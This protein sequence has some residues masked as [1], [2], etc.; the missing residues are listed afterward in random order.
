[1]TTVIGTDP[2]G[3]RPVVPSRGDRRPLGLNEVT[4]TGGLW[5]RLQE[6]NASATLAHCER[7][8]ERLGWL[9]NFD[10]VADGTTGPERP[11]WSFS[12]SEVYK[13]IE[14]MC[15]EH[16]R[17]GAPGLDESIRRLTARVGRAQDAD[18]YLNTC[19]GHAGRPPRYS[20]LEEGHELYN[21]GHLLQAAVARLRTS[22]AD[23]LVDLARR[24]ADHVCEVF[25][26]DGI[27]GHPE[28]EVGLAELGRAMGESR[29]VE[30]ARRFLDRRGHGTL[31]DIP[32]GRAYFQDDVPIREAATF[33]G[34]AVR[35]LYLSAA[36]VD[37]AVELADDPL[38]HAIERQ[39]EHAVARRTYLTGGMGS[40][41]QDEGF[42]EDWELPPD[43]AYCE[44]CAGVASIMVSWRL[45]LATGDVRYADL[46]ERTFYNII[47]TSPRS[48][49]RAF[50]YANPL[51]QRTP[52]TPGDDSAV[53]PRAEGGSRAAWFDVSCCP[54]NV[55]RTLA[56]W[57]TYLASAGE[58]DLTLLQY[59]PSRITTDL[60]GG[61]FAIEVDTAYPDDG[62]VTIHVLSAPRDPVALR[63]RVPP[64][65]SGA[66]LDDGGG[67][68]EV[69]PGLVAVGR[70][71]TAGETLRLRLPLAPRFTW[72]DRRVDAVRGCV[73][74][75]R[76]PLVL[77]AES[78]D[79]PGIRL[80]DVAV[81]PAGLIER[82]GQVLA[83]ARA[84][85]G[86]GSA[87]PYG[88]ASASGSG[89]AFELPLVP[90]HRWAE[91]GPTAM[92]VWLPVSGGGP[93]RA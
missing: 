31:R 52:G 27:C 21:T 87:W 66:V 54:T 14:A 88:P 10:R 16:G 92:R 5:A 73:A 46:M 83:Q 24:A 30:Q 75:E 9:A 80:D 42:G 60:T 18:G 15:W 23:E 3:G 41:H 51:H 17:S 50:F 79:L 64:W 35:A 65:A 76:G 40:R 8:M 45:H 49:G 12:D 6:T 90:Y 56:S 59:A 62:A 58:R 84:V 81:S 7:W 38:L 61:R 72:P 68:R 28:I 37:V 2:A 82:D 25:A 48:D 34:H 13:L 89:D 91:R 33:R 11:G 47:A 93:P 19:F 44:T 22:G 74:V 55:A 57:H 69:A 71:F 39:W 29:Y 70:V 43:R 26:T 77:C 67:Q 1:M 36:A 63:L 53:S 4:V 78:L 86:A 20:D 85:A 32:L